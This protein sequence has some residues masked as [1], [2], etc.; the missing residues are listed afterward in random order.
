[1]YSMERKGKRSTKNGKKE[2]KRRS[3]FVEVKESG[4]RRGNKDFF[5]Q[6]NYATNDY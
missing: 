1:M 2:E 3:W 4:K 6:T 5:Y